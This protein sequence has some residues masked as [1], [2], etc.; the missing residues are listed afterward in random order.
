MLRIYTDQG[1]WS[2]LNEFWMNFGGNLSAAVMRLSLISFSSDASN[3]LGFI[4]YS[5]ITSAL[6]LISYLILF[7]WL[8]SKKLYQLNPKEVILC[9]AA[10]FIFEGLFTPGSSSIYLFGAASGVHVWPICILIITLALIT[11]KE[12]SK[13]IGVRLFRFG[14]FV[15]LGFV[16]GNSGMAEGAASLCLIPVLI[17]MTY[18]SYE[19]GF[20]KSSIRYLQSLFL[21][22]LFGFITIFIAPGFKSRLSRDSQLVDLSGNLLEQFRS[23]L[24]SF[25][26]E[27]LTHP[28]WL[29]L[30]LALPKMSLVLSCMS[31]VRAKVLTYSFLI[32]FVLTVLG[33]TF[34]YAAWHQ[35]GGLLVLFTPGLLAV[36]ALLSH[37]NYRGSMK[38][39]RLLSTGLLLVATLIFCL[40][41][42]GLYFQEKRSTEW[43]SNLVKNYCLQLRG[44]GEKFLGAEIRYW[45]LGLGIEDVNRWKWMSDD[46]AAWL[47]TLG[48]VLKPK[49]I[50]SP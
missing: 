11:V 39:S 26:G 2:T 38:T 27:L 5:L 25:S 40:T 14:S 48:P 50:E 37:K 17:F 44:T 3:W 12:K 35:S 33:S 18:R 1:F 41:L 7:A 34:G 49:C 31:K 6:I 36:S 19:L 10:T 24:V 32:L 15:T 21:G 13:L 42:R 28:I 47:K 9:L 22:I 20:D 4:L 29:L 23:S 45:P 43:E 30:L 16:I 8:N 46:Y